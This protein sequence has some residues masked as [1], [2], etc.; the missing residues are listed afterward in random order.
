M[1]KSTRVKLTVH[2]TATKKLVL[3]QRTTVEP[4]RL[5]L[6]I[7][8]NCAL[9]DGQFAAEPLLADTAQSP[10]FFFH[11]PPH[12]RVPSPIPLPAEPPH[13]RPPFFISTPLQR[14]PS[15]PCK[16]WPARERFVAVARQTA[17]GSTLVGTSRNTPI[18]SPLSSFQPR[19]IVPL[20]SCQVL[21]A[22]DRIVTVA[23][24]RLWV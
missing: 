19:P 24:K 1:A 3:A 22:S 6:H 2:F 5:Q 9:L 10:I 15:L 4:H 13:F 23:G 14:S 18:S 20:P 21:A 12:T 17:P 8:F 11:Y 16:G 7:D